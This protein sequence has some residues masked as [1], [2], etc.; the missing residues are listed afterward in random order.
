M[1]SGDSP[2][3]GSTW[4]RAPTPRRPLSWWTDISDLPGSPREPPIP[5][6]RGIPSR[7]SKS[8]TLHLFRFK[9][10]SSG[11]QGDKRSRE[12]FSHDELPTSIIGRIMARHGLQRNTTPP[13]SAEGLIP[14]PNQS[15]NEAFRVSPGSLRLKL[16]GNELGL[17]GREKPGISSARY[18]S[19]TG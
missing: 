15:A 4:P 9:F 5:T 8:Q 1:N 16:H 7:Q 17:P 13:R 10:A 3:P 19:L 6:D 18:L 12:G 2:G 11:C 14:A